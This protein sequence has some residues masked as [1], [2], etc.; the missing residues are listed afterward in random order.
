M[1]YIFAALFCMACFAASSGAKSAADSAKPSYPPTPRGDTVDTYYGTKVPDPYRWLESLNSPQTRHWVG[2]ENTLTLRYLDT[3]T[4]L[5]AQL[6]DR[7]AKLEDYDMMLSPEHHGTVWARWHSKGPGFHFVLYVSGSAEKL[8]SLLLDPATFPNHEVIGAWVP[9][10]FSPDGRYLAYATSVPGSIWDTWHVRDVAT[11]RDLPDA[12]VDTAYAW[13]VWQRDSSG[14]YYAHYPAEDL[15]SSLATLKGDVLYFHRLQTSQAH[16]RVVYATAKDA[17]WFVSATATSDG[18]YLIIDSAKNLGPKETYLVADLRHDFRLT[19]ISLSSG[20][21]LG[22][23][24]P[25]LYFFTFDGA[26]RGRVAC[27]DLSRSGRISTLVPQQVDV[28]PDHALMGGIGSEVS[29]QQPASLVGNRFYIAYVHDAHVIVKSF[30]LDGTPAGVLSLPGVGTADAPTSGVRSDRY[31]YYDYESYTTAPETFRYDTLTGKSAL[32]WKP[33]VAG[34]VSALVT[35]L[36]YATSKDGTKVPMFVTHGRD[37]VR[38]GR[39]PTSIWTYGGPFYQTTPR[40]SPATL[41]WVEMGGVSVDA[42]PRGGI[43][44]GD[45]WHEA[46]VGVHKQ[47]TYDDVI[48]CAEK[49]IEDKWTSPRRLA[50]SGASEGALTA[51]AVVTQRPDLFDVVVLDSGLYDMVRGDRLGAGMVASEFGSADASEAQFRALY[52]YSPYHHVRAGV[53]Y[54]AMLIVAGAD[55]QDVFPGHSLKFAAALQHAQ[56]GAAPILMYEFSDK[57]H[58]SELPGEDIGAFTLRA[59]GVSPASL[60][61]SQKPR[62]QISRR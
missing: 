21:L 29:A 40:F 8:G 50:L 34:D 35:D 13:P 2:E 32:V 38:N 7:A 11:K 18:R 42:Y 61:R 49:L 44:F 47:R 55:D 56:A 30:K 48:A 33:H 12:L 58:W 3:L 4:P 16:D 52:A 9:Y 51:A 57:G 6:R 26:P 45:A 28:A 17:L 25:R 20:A 53:R 43:E 37:L 41:Q 36:V 39:A 46:A 62:V 60:H 14:F 15:G 59:M 22:N 24:G 1:R 19:H 23:D 5:R 54:P 10:V 31:V 27:V